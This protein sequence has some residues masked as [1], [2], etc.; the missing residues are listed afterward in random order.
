MIHDTREKRQAILLMESE[1]DYVNDELDTS[2]EYFRKKKKGNEEDTN[3]PPEE[4]EA[5]HY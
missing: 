4:S 5:P 3:S 2:E 1:I